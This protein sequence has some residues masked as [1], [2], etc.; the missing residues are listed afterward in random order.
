MRSLNKL[1]LALALLPSLALADMTVDP[2][3]TPTAILSCQL[4]V[5]REDGTPL[6]VNE[7]ATINFYAGTTIGDY[8]D[9]I[10]MTSCS[11]SI[12]ITKLVDAPY[13]YVVTAVDTDGR[14]SMYSPMY[15][16]TVKRVKPPS[17][18]S[19]N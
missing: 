14:E 18:P 15:T 16:L 6:A 7:I 10:G 13:Y 19:W 5:E 8:T 11:M 4:P 2:V 17:A 12:D 1:L 9:T 3:I